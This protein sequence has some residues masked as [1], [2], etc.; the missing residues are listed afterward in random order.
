MRLVEEQVGERDVG[1]FS[2]LS[3]GRGELEGAA[4][5]GDTRVGADEEAGDGF[6]VVELAIDFDQVGGDADFLV[7]LAKR[8]GAQ[9]YVLRIAGGA[10]EADLSFVVAD[11]VCAL[12]EDEVVLASVFVEQEED[13]GGPQR[14]EFHFAWFVV[15]EGLTDTVAE[16][17]LPRR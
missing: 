4:A 14:A 17:G 5:R 10:G 9:V 15:G 11:S 16:H 3:L 6:S 8:G 1:Q 7:G 2:D 13:A 12:L